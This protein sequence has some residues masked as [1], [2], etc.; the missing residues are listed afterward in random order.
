[1]R[2]LRA[3]RLPAFMRVPLRPKAAV[4]P[5]QAWNKRTLAA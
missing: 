1:M 5:V 4:A 2:L 3:V